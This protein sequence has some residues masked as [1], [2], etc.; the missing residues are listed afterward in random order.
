[1]VRTSIVYNRVYIQ[2]VLEGGVA[3]GE[4]RVNERSLAKDADAQAMCSSPRSKRSSQ[5]AE[6]RKKRKPNPT[7]YSTTPT[8]QS[9][10]AIVGFGLGLCCNSSISQT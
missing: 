1:M 5:K 10:T 7:I 3:A 4:V 8:R 6:A 9:P 2:S